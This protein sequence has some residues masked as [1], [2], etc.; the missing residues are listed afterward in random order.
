V[1]GHDIIVVGASAGG[2]EA[3]E[4][5]TK[6]LPKNVPAALFLVLHQAPTV[7]SLLPQLITNRTGFPAIH[8]NNGDNLEPGRLYVAPPDYHMILKD[9][10]ILLDHG[11]KENRHRPAVD[12]LFRSAAIEYGP[13]VIGV[14]LT[15]ALDDGTGGLMAVKLC[16]GI[17]VVQHP[18]DAFCAGM[19]ENAL[20]VVEVD[21]CL[22]LT[23]IPNLLLDLMKKPAKKKEEANCNGVEFENI[24][25][26]H[27][28]TPKEMQQRFGHPSGFIC[29]ECSGPLWEVRARKHTQ[30]RC[31]VGHQFSPESFLAEETEALER[32]LWTAI[33][34]LEER[35]TFL[36]NL[37]ERSQELGETST[38][39]TFRNKAFEN[40]E[41][42]EIIRRIATRLKV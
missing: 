21:H 20:R 28:L 30:Y 22:P 35:V 13:R 5:L 11:P 2:V 31:L 15:G 27:P 14:I 23:K 19:P 34:T 16:G 36:N 17:A 7:R 41:H 12:P 6:N 40:K 37:A 38:F 24:V 25:A 4:I 1:Q 26:G 29:P 10:K 39:E 18:E 9:G 33:K 42:A 3:I 32:A 8:P